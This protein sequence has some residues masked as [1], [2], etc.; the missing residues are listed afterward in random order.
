VDSSGAAAAA[1]AAAAAHV[2]VRFPDDGQQHAAGQG[3]AEPVLGASMLKLVFPSAQVLEGPLGNRMLHHVMEAAFRHASLH[4]IILRG[5][6]DDAALPADEPPPTSVLYSA[7][8]G[9]QRVR[10]L[11]LPPC[12]SVHVHL[13]SLALCRSIQEL[14][15]DAR[16]A[17]RPRAGGGEG[18][19]QQLLP[20][21]PD[22]ASV[23]LAGCPL[24]QA[25]SLQTLRLLGFR[26]CSEF[27]VV[28]LLGALPPLRELAVSVGPGQALPSEQAERAWEQRMGAAVFGSFGLQVASAEAL[29]GGG[30]LFTA[31]LPG[32]QQ[33]A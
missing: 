17:Q 15:I 18:Q 23:F 2:T 16:P 26:P 29:D 13:L 21:P 33:G 28:R 12:S 1:A 25:G 4:T 11:A 3:D 32:W 27:E 30:V 8:P 7:V 9:L 5:S 22:V 10:L 19:P 24:Q 6:P 31:R 14:V 20:E